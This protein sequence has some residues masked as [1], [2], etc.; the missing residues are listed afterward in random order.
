MNHPMLPFERSR[1]RFV[2]GLALGG[3]AVSLG[4]HRRAAAAPVTNS[5]PV[6]SGTEFNLDIAELPVNFTGRSRVAT[7]IN[8]SLPGPILRWR[9][10]PDVTLR[11]TNRLKVQS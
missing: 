3:A 6:L 5:M 8:G 4:V 7:A 11:V 9:E 10:G 2:Q 1:R